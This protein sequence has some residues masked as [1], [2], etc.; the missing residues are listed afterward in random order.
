MFEKIISI[1]YFSLSRNNRSLQE[2][3]S[4]CRQG[5][6]WTVASTD[7]A[8]TN[9]H[10]LFFF[11]TSIVEMVCIV[12][13]LNVGKKKTRSAEMFSQFSNFQSFSSQNE[14]VFS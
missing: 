12:L 5:I 1:L 14:N 10:F 13:R 11:I 8:I 7:A 9:M 4:T 2:F 6:T 3:Q